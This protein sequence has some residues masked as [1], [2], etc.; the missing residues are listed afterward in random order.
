MVGVEQAGG[1]A[2][3]RGA[4]GVA[5]PVWRRGGQE[6]EGG[7]FGGVAAAVEEQ[8]GRWDGGPRGSARPRRRRSRA[9]AA[10]RTWPGIALSA[11]SY[12]AILLSRTKEY[13]PGFCPI[14]P[15]SGR[16]M[17]ANPPY[18]RHRRRDRRSGLRAQPRRRRSSRNC[19]RQTGRG[20]AHQHPP[21]RGL[22]LRPRAQYFTARHPE[23]I[24]ESRG[25]AGGGVAAPWLARLTVFDADG[26]RGLHR[27]E[28][29]SSARRV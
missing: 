21:R 19:P 25:L 26:R 23:F 2:P 13:I 8:V 3:R 10:Q 22:G 27:Q 6:S 5:E 4:A 18:C 9:V 17:N 12:E 16:L 28:G 7:R 20:R 11:S 29:A 1:R 15:P 24:E 14:L